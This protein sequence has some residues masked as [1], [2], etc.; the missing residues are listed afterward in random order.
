MRTTEFRRSFRR[1]AIAGAIA[2]VSATTPA[3]L[4]AQVAVDTG[5]V[6]TTDVGDARARRQAKDLIGLLFRH[7]AGA[8]RP[9]PRRRTSLR[10]VTPGGLPAVE[11]SGQ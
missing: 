8:P 4:A 6:R 11:I 1:A 5:A 3:I 9:R 2:L 7:F 10:V